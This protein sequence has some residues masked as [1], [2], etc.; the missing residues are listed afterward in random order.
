MFNEWLKEKYS[1][2]QL[3][4]GAEQLKDQMTE[5]TAEVKSIKGAFQTLK[6]KGIHG[7][8]FTGSLSSLWY[9]SQ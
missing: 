4:Q 6:E 1:G 2:T 5:S 9:Y 8:E 3:A 7:G